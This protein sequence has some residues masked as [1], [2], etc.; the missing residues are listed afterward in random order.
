MDIGGSEQDPLSKVVLRKSLLFYSFR[1][2]VKREQ[3][4]KLSKNPWLYFSFVTVYRIVKPKSSPKSKSKLILTKFQGLTLP[5]PSLVLYYTLNNNFFYLVS[6][7]ISNASR[8][9]SEPSGAQ[10]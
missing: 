7:T 8:T 6:T 5:T 3:T 9:G 1:N 2:I 10:G 4:N